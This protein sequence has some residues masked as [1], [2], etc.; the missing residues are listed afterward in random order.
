MQSVVRL[1]IAKAEPP[2]SSGVTW[3]TSRRPALPQPWQRH[4]SRSRAFR[5]T[6]PQ[7][8]RGILCQDFELLCKG[9]ALGDGSPGRPTPCTSSECQG[10]RHVVPRRV[11]RALLDHP[12]V[13][14]GVVL[15][16]GGRQGRCY[17][18]PVELLYRRGP[19][20][21][22][23]RSARMSKLESDH[24]VRRVSIGQ[25][26]W[27]ASRSSLTLKRSHSRIPGAPHAS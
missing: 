9:H 19:S 12:G 22:I 25:L 17:Q 18:R 27:T 15:D 5:L 23:D 20:L 13:A 16:P 11:I 1:Y 3:W 7:R 8:R 14:V 6:T 24:L 2:A 10:R 26:P 4:R 21:A